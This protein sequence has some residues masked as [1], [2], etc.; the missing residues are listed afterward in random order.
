MKYE[1]LNSEG[2][3]LLVEKIGGE[4]YFKLL[5]KN[6]N[7][8]GKNPYKLIPTNSLDILLF[9]RG[10]WE[11][12]DVDYE[13]LNFRDYSSDYK[14]KHKIKA[15]ISDLIKECLNDLND[16]NSKFLEQFAL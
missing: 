1:L 9:L 7:L 2:P 10:D 5:L 13:S 11:I 16:S 3:F 12:F 14:N 4:W 8:P 6:S 15:L